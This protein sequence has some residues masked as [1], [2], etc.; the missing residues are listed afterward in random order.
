MYL[1]YG[2]YMDRSGFTHKTY[3]HLHDLI[4][5][6]IDTSYDYYTVWQVEMHVGDDELIEIYSNVPAEMRLS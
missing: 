5:F 2:M 1:V 4:Q 6:L 3:S